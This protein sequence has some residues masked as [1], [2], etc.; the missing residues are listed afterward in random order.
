MRSDK[1]TEKFVR[2]VRMHTNAQKN[3]AVLRTLLRQFRSN[4]EQH[5]SGEPPREA[6]K[7]QA[8]RDS[9][10]KFVRVRQ[11]HSAWRR[12]KIAAA[13]ILIAGVAFLGGQLSVRPTLPT[14]VNVAGQVGAEP[15]GVNVPSELVAWLEAAR[16]FRQ[17]GMQDRMARAVERAGRLLP[18]DT[19]I[20]DGHNLRVFAAESVVNQKERI[21]LMDMLSIDS[22]T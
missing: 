18:V 4:Q 9:K 17:L 10:A 15:D 20:A 8:L 16:L 11:R 21:E 13:A 5:L 6:F 7:Q 1:K 3:E 19:I 14:S 22:I 2:G 12:S